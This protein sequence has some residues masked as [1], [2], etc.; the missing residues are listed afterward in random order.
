MKFKQL[1]QIVPQFCEQ[2]LCSIT[3]WLILLEYGKLVAILPLAG[4]LRQQYT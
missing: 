3:L 2:L 1:Y 4:L